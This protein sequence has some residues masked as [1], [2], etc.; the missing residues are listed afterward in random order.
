[1]R[2]AVAF[3]GPDAHAHAPRRMYYK[4]RMLELVGVVG[5][6]RYQGG[7]TWIEIDMSF[8]RKK[9]KAPPAVGTHE[10]LHTPKSQPSP[11]Q[12]PEEPPQTAEVSV[13]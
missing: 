4:L 12:I 8:F 2:S 5:R 1:M 7:E 11:P 10:A 6:P 3:Y 9:K 13:N